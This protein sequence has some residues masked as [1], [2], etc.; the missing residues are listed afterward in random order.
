LDQAIRAAILEANRELIALAERQPE[1][2]GM[3]STVVAGVVHEYEL[4]YCHVGDSRAYLLRE[5]QIEQLTGDDTLVQGLVSAG[6]LTAGEARHHPMRH[7]LLHSI[8]TRP[9]EK[10]LQ[11]A[12][13][14]LC[15]GDR[16]LFTSDGVT[17]AVA[18][19]GLR[20]SLDSE[21]DPQ[22]AANEL[23]DLAARSGARD[24]ITCIVVDLWEA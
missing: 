1:L 15:P 11:V 6:V 4:R 5:G 10:D 21:P 2:D 7:V 20:Q 16:L 18:R 12:A 19:D 14:K 13:L 22:R 23:A 17:D 9:L 8:C 24:N 3:G